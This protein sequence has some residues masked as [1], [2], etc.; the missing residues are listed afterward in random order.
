[1]LGTGCP[2]RHALPLTIRRKRNYRDRR[3]PP[4]RA[5]S[6]FGATSPLARVWAKARNPPNSAGSRSQLEG[7]LRGKKAPSQRGGSVSEQGP[8]AVSR[9]LKRSRDDLDDEPAR[10]IIEISA[11]GSG[12][13][14]RGSRVA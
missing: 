10:R 14:V 2:G 13:T 7:R 1:M 9:R 5:G 11:G 8:E 4:A 3:S 6:F 12:L